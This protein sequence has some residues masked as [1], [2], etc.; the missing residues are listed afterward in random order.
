MA[1]VPGALGPTLG[2]LSSLTAPIR[3]ALIGMGAM[4]KGLLHQCRI[5]PGME[6]VAVADLVAER[7][8]R[9]AE[10]AG[11]PY[12]LASTPG[13]V[14]DA[15]RQGF[16]AICEDSMLVAA[17]P[18]ATVLVESTS[19]IGEAGRY[20][21]TAVETGK[22][23]VMMN[24]EAD[25]AF[26]PYLM[27]LARRRGVVYTSCGGDQHGVIRNLI[28]EIQLWGFDLVMAGNIK[29]F[30]DR[31]SNPTK[32]VPEADARN[33]DYRM[34]TAFTDGTKLCVEMSLVANAFGL[35][36][37]VPGMHG[38]RADDVQDVL[39]V[40]DF[41]SLDA[42]SRPC[43]DYILGATPGG[44]VFVVGYC[45]H[46]Y[47]REML[48]Y[49]KKGRGPF[50]LFYRPYHLCHIEAMN[51]IVEAVVDGRSL[52]EPLAGFRTNVFA[53]AKRGLHAGEKLDG[54]GGYTCYGMIENCDDSA[55]PGIPI[56]LSENLV[57]RR[58]IVQD[59]PIAMCDVEGGDGRPDFELYAQ[60]RRASGGCS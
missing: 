30:L 7:A 47:Q 4:G 46:P 27:R 8:V 20:A 13:Q 36:T 17:C 19:A 55:H 10:M 60:A 45:D 1:N 18:E 22:H 50:Y 34:A 35:R 14:Q 26:G 43:V 59:S 28:D 54:I 6:C 51:C 29:G 49:Y 25:L 33:L 21:V 57:L 38:P 37:T 31:Y 58:D 41:E 16:L 15:I 53:Y 42:R 48:A 52:L 44:G 2:K 9:C 56:A 12:R 11:L 23:L 5:T 24:A 3:I 32:I 39:S 40:F